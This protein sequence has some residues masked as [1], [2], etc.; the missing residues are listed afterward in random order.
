MEENLSREAGAKHEDNVGLTIRFDFILQAME[1]HE[2][3]LHWERN[4]QMC[5]LWKIYPNSYMKNGQ[6]TRGD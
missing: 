2:T 5:K 4:D 6:E 3:A 1:N